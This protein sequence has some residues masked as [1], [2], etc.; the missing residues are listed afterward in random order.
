MLSP[1]H[2]QSFGQRICSVD[3]KPGMICIAERILSMRVKEHPILGPI[4]TDSRNL[5]HIVV[6]GKTIEAVEGEPIAAALFAAGIRVMRYTERKKEPRSIFCAI[7]R[8]TDCAM[9]VDGIPNVKTCVTKVRDGMVVETQHG[10][11]TWREKK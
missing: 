7:G 1:E 9:I 5:V 11:G 2:E 8:C 4:E 3:H 10:R 6:D